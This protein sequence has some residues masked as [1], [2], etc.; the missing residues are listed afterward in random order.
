MTVV[1]GHNFSFP[2]PEEYTV[3]RES[4]EA[5]G[6]DS[7]LNKLWENASKH[8]RARGQP[9]HVIRGALIDAK[10][11]TREREMSLEETFIGLLSPSHGQ[12][13]E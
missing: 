12:L 5:L 13:K 8:R 11:E 4:A 3:L 6:A 7:T 9:Y 10:G 2:L 1:C